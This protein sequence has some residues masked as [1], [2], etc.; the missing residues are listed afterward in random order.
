MTNKE[1]EDTVLNHRYI[2][3]YRDSVL[4][5]H[6]A[7]IAQGKSFEDSRYLAL[8][9]SQFL[10]EELGYTNQ[11]TININLETP[12]DLEVVTTDKTTIHVTK[13]EQETLHLA[14]NVLQQQGFINTQ[15]YINMLEVL[16]V[17]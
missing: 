9:Q 14:M 8:E 10:M 2:Q 6:S 17:K 1:F 13:A 7:F 15:G 16:K 11:D 5:L 4:N 12:S 3:L